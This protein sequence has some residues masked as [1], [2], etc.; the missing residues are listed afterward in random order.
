[1]QI[2]QAAPVAQRLQD[3]MKRPDTLLSILSVLQR[4]GALNTALN[5]VPVEVT[6]T[7]V[8]DDESA[9]E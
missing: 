5:S 7:E 4:S 2:N 9:D 1:M 3:D 6:E 8:I